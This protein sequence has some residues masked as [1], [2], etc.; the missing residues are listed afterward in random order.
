METGSHSHPS[1][2][3]LLSLLVGDFDLME[4]ISVRTL[5]PNLLRVPA[6]R[7]LRFNGNFNFL[8]GEC[9]IFMSLL[10]GDFDLMETQRPPPE[11]KPVVGPC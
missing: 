9:H 10:V 1:H 8:W 3:Q 7:G 2:S 6:S 4:T 5:A 11:G